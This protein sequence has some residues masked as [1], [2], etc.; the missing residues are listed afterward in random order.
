MLTLYSIVAVHGLDESS[1]SAWTDAPTGCCWLSDLLAHDMPR[2]RILTFDYKADA[3]T[4]LVVVHRV[5][6]RT[7]RRHY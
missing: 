5:G 7:M 3:T 4:F 2:A 1:H 6:Y